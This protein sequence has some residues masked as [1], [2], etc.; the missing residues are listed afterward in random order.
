MVYGPWRGE[1]GDQSLSVSGRNGVL[2]KPEW[3]WVRPL[4]LRPVRGVSD[5]VRAS[6][7]GETGSRFEDFWRK[8]G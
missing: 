4:F 7:I 1:S 8:L 6:Q 3:E 2:V 5:R